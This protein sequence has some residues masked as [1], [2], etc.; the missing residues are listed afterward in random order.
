MT[1]L[2]CGL[3]RVQ[4]YFLF[5]RLLHC[6]LAISQSRVITSAEWA[7]A[8]VVL[9]TKFKMTSI[10]CGSL[11][12][13]IFC[14]MVCLLFFFK[15]CILLHLILPLQIAVLGAI[16]MIFISIYLIFISKHLNQAFWALGEPLQYRL[17]YTILWLVLHG[18]IPRLV[19]LPSSP[20]CTLPWFAPRPFL[21]SMQLTIFHML[22]QL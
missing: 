6:H 3:L 20:G 13:L 12:V 17:P 10:V 16:P 18:H 4:F 19:P 9:F 2:S 21:L 8:L 22:N 15:Q 1:S 14:K 5:S 7:H 11:R